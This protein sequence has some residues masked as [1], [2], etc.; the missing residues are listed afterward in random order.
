MSED[1]TPSQ[2]A[3]QEA[4][5]IIENLKQHGA[6]DYTPGRN[7]IARMFDDYIW[8]GH[9][10]CTTSFDEVDNPAAN[11]LRE[12]RLIQEDEYDQ[13]MDHDE[14][15]PTWDAM[16]FQAGAYVWFADKTS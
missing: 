9:W 15:K 11:G 6:G 12:L 7:E 16:L 3:L 1:Y 5:R 10:D 14:D 2:D 13:H 4:D 8:N